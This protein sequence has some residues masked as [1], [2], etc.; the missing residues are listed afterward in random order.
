MIHVDRSEKIYIIISVALIAVF[1]VAVAV[2]SFVYGIQVPLPESRVDPRTI[3]T[4]A[5][6]NFFGEPGLYEVGPGKYNAYIMSQIWS[7]TPRE[8]T[9]PVGS[10]VTFYV[11]S[12]DVQHGFRINETNVDMQIVP[13][14][15]SKLT[16]TFDEARE[17]DYIC[18]EY[19]GVGH[20]TMAGK[21]IVTEQ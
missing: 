3:A 10:T 20:Q 4:P 11:T 13:G 15:V 18:H 1:F 17:Y 9:V 7:F 14:E 21:I 6:G 5:P 8:I 19:C 2:S 16:V 12:K